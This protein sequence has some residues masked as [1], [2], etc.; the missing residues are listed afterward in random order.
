MSG[1]AERNLEILALQVRV[2]QLQATTRSWM[3]KQQPRE[4]GRRKEQILLYSFWREYHP[5]STSFRHSEADL[6]LLASRT[7]RE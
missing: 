7:I 6:R 3:P 1:E 4:A 5:A 2:M